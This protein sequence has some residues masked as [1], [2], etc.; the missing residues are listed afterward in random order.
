MAAVHQVPRTSLAASPF[1]GRVW[2]TPS[3]AGDPESP[4]NPYTPAA[5]GKLNGAFAPSPPA[6]PS[7]SGKR[8]RLRKG[9]RTARPRTAGSQDFHPPSPWLARRPSSASP[10]AG[11]KRRPQSAPP[12]AHA[13]P[14]AAEG[15]VMSPHR[16]EVE[17]QLV[18]GSAVF[19]GYERENVQYQLQQLHQLEQKRREREALLRR[20][21]TESVGLGASLGAVVPTSVA[22]MLELELR[23]DQALLRQHAQVLATEKA[24]ARI[25]VL[26]A[27]LT[28]KEARVVAG[29]QELAMVADE[30]DQRGGVLAELSNQAEAARDGLDGVQARVARERVARQQ[31]LDT[32][33]SRLGVDALHSEIK[34]LETQLGD[35]QET[36]AALSEVRGSIASREH[37]LQDLQEREGKQ[38]AVVATLRARKRSHQNTRRAKDVRADMAALE[39]ELAGVATDTAAREAELA[40][41]KQ[42]MQQSAVVS[43]QLAVAIAAVEENEAAAAGTSGRKAKL[44]KQ[45]EEELEALARLEGILTSA[46]A[47]EELDERQ[48]AQLRQ[49]VNDATAELSA[50]HKELDAELHVLV[51][52]EATVRETIKSTEEALKKLEQKMVKNAHDIQQQEH[53]IADGGEQLERV[54][55]A[56]A[57]KRAELVQMRPPAAVQADLDGIHTQM[58][59]EENHQAVVAEEMDVIRGQMKTQSECADQL[60]AAKSAL[61]ALSTLKAELEAKAAAAKTREI[62]D[63]QAIAEAEAK[64]DAAHSRADEVKRILDEATAVLEAK[65]AKITAEFDAGEQMHIEAIESLK[66]ITIRQLEELRSMPHPP[67]GVELTLSAVMLIIGRGSKLPWTEIKQILHEKIFMADVMKF[68]QFRDSTVKHRALHTLQV[69]YIDDERFNVDSVTHASKAAGPLCAWVKSQV[70]LAHT[71]AHMK[72][73]D[74]ACE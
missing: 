51:L 62:V 35:L 69:E 46:R 25:A 59:T 7:P 36:T 55:E 9:A 23:L 58:E 50:R 32:L 52:E 56:G 1:K 12:G 64:R 4:A 31:E 30:V 28:I 63:Q 70:H 74:A 10:R 19:L 6:T 38:S 15:A 49:E 44:E 21:R 2:T 60:D 67:A 45:H 42:V 27:K 40:D 57:V 8:K 18:H 41:I 61:N 5:V 11:G 24:T 3:S 17:D 72:N 26:Q 47:E 68:D 65:R 33:R 20:L 71:S 48:V 73:L 37:R 54:H 34:E 29:R 22:R 13:M 39:D 43:R 14:T 66:G 16:A 53:S